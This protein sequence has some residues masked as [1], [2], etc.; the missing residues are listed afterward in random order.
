MAEHQPARGG[1]RE[2]MA[3]FV[4]RRRRE[5]ETFGQEAEAAAR[6]AY[7]RAIRAGDDLVLNTQGQVMRY[8]ADLVG[9]RKASTQVRAG[10]SALHARGPG[11]A[12]PATRPPA[13]QPVA[14]ANGRQG[15]SWLDRSPAAKAV[16]GD[17]ARLVGNA[18]GVVRGGVH[19]VEGLADGAVFLGRLANPW[20]RL[21]SP[22]GQSA[23]EQLADAGRGVVDYAQKGFA[24]P[25]RVVRDV[26]AKA[27]QMRIDLDP[28]ATPMAPTF[29]GELR[30]N[31]D[32]GQNQGELAF[33]VGSFVVGGP[34]AKSVKGLGAVSK[35]ANAGKY[36]AQG[37]SPKV[38]AYLAEPYKG[39][40]HHYG[41]RRL[42]LPSNYSDSVFNVLKPEG[43]TRGD[44]YELHFKVDPQFNHA[45]LPAKLGLKSWNGKALGLKK[46]GL[47]GR[48][49]HGSPAPLKAR[50]GG[51]G[52]SLG[53]LVEDVA[54]EDQAW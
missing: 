4:N 23:A 21:I 20:D 37:F 54:D 43:I 48:M 19:T 29:A 26:Q 35:T 51:L 42:G 27:H 53:G 36:I 3:E 44:M 49:W 13:V 30:R 50:V 6:H 39:M 46:Y 11:A 17:A 9:A 52:A 34:L 15:G 16:G 47:P 5:V 1:L 31:L 28:G 8:G 41:P 12:R 33:D 25:Q 40:G 2:T 14:S 22:P 18:A 45:P 38:A 10:S 24:D 32:I 7:G